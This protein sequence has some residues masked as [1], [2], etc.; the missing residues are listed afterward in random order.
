MP[1]S[2]ESTPPVS[3]HPLLRSGRPR[4][5]GPQMSSSS[6]RRG[7][8]SRPGPGTRG[9]AAILLRSRRSR[10][11]SGRRSPPPSRGSPGRSPSSHSR[12]RRSRS[13]SGRRSPPPSRSSP[14]RSPSRPTYH[15]SHR[16]GSPSPSWPYY[17]YCSSRSPP[18]RSYDSRNISP[19][20]YSYHHSHPAL[21][22]STTTAL[23]IS[24][25][26]SPPASGPG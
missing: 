23:P 14:R 1:S 6:R 12:S 13:P 11:P 21:F 24:S 9:P 5:P 4:R 8:P 25:V 17:H 16:A 26:R 22:L 18:R 15:R 19:G 20:P 2:D 7:T 10:S 3:P